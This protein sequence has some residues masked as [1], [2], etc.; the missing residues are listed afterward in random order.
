MI[1]GIA[2]WGPFQSLTSLQSCQPFISAFDVN[3]TLQRFYLPSKR[4]LFTRPIA[5]WRLV[6]RLKVEAWDYALLNSG[7]SLLLR[8]DLLEKLLQVCQDRSIA[9]VVV[10]H[11]HLGK[12]D[13]I[14]DRIGDQRYNALRSKLRS[15]EVNHLAVSSQTASDISIELEID[16]PPNIR[17][18]RAIPS[19]YQEI[20]KPSSARSIISVAQVNANKRPDR[21][22]D[23][24]ER[25]CRE[26]KEV[27]FL[28]IGGQAPTELKARIEKGGFSSRIRFLPF[29]NDPFKYMV[30]AYALILPSQQE[31]F[32]LVL[33][34]A[35][36]VGRTVYCFDGTGA[37]EVSGSKDQVFEQDDLEGPVRAI[38]ALLR[39]SPTDAINWDARERYVAL[40]SPEAYARSLA[41]E[42]HKAVDSFRSVTN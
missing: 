41:S 31:A 36:G 38:T 1:K 26:D 40:Y 28:W 23:I 27:E 6:R 9:P 7:A 11:N 5:D 19:E 10:W 16:A 33:A 18:C 35:M 25:V 42:I 13:E 17:N 22:V 37:A 39:K 20:R 4:S 30:E 32:G 24:A 34:E 29:T 12:F 21:F 8:P 3:L 2:T 15:P 14:K